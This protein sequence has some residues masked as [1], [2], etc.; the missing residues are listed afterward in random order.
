MRAITDN[1]KHVGSGW[2]VEREEGR[3]I[4]DREVE[5]KTLGARRESGSKVSIDE[6]FD[7][8][9][10]SKVGEAREFSVEKGTGN[11]CQD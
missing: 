11:W 5:D 9:N 2:D 3:F 8:R 10:G 6:G 1:E 7:G 4:L